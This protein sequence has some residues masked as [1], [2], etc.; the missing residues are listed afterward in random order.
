MY[1]E[2]CPVT[3]TLAQVEADLQ[4]GNLSSAQSSARKLTNLLEP[5][6]PELAKQ[7]ELVARSNTLAEA[8]SNLAKLDDKIMASMSPS[9]NSAK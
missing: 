9:P 3:T 2:A 6:M 5:T 1:S 7:A 4:K 8:K